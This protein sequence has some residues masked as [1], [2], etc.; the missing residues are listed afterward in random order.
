M[1][2]DIISILFGG[3]EKIARFFSTSYFVLTLKLFLFIYIVVLLID[4]ILLLVLR[5]LSS[6]F[7]K[8]FF[9]SERPL[10]ARTTV[11]RR[12]ESIL[13]RL[14]SVNPSQ[15]KVAVL[16]ADEFADEILLGIGYKGATMTEKLATVKG[17]Q[18]E[19][20]DI[21]AE[22]HTMR[23]RIVHEADFSLSREEAEKCLDSYRKFFDEVELF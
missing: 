8:L 7:R 20:K 22:A 4:V 21:L 16:E 6:D 19:S 13:A 9:G 3:G 11:I 14:E 17:G 5:G 1:D 12:W 2:V 18:L 10:I 15:Y 23:N